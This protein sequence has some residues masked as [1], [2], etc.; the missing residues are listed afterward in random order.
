MIKNEKII[1]IHRPIE[2][3]FA[4]VSD[5]QNG[6]RWQPELLDVHPITEGTLGIGSKFTSTRKFL[7]RSMESIVEFI[8]Y[9]PNKKIVFKSTPGTMPMEASYL[10]EPMDD[11]TRLSAMVEMQPEGIMRL[12]EPMIAASLKRE[13]ETHFEGLKDLLENEGN[14]VPS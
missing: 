14:T 5:L 1:N 7:G 2:S 8:A 3:V 9:E 4:F 6:P 11:G 12:A 10:F 13:M